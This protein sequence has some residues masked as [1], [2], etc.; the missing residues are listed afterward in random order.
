MKKLI[1]FFTLQIYAYQAFTQVNLFPAYNQTFGTTDIAGTWTDN[2]TFIGWYSNRVTIAHQDVTAAA[3][4]NTGALYSYECSGNNNQKLGSR[5]SG[6]TGTIRYGVRLVNNTAGT[7]HF[8]RITFDAFQFS[9]ADD[10]G[11]QTITCSYLV[12]PTA[13]N[14]NAGGFT[15]I[16]ALNF[17]ALQTNGGACG[18]SQINGFPCTQTANISTCLAVNISSGQE[19]MIKWEDADDSGNDHHMGIDNVNITAYSNSIFDPT[20]SCI[21]PLPVEL[22]YFKLECDNQRINAQ[23]ETSSEINNSHFILQGS[24]DAIQYSDLEIIPGNGNSNVLQNYATSIN[25]IMGYNYFRLVQSDYDGTT[26]YYD[27]KTINCNAHEN[28]FSAYYINDQLYLELP[29]ELGKSS[30][31]VADMTGKTILSKEVDNNTAQLHLNGGI[32]IISLFDQENLKQFVAKVL[33]LR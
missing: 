26:T 27:P 9:L 29:P 13:N 32:Y 30:F 10:C 3:P 12:A 14:I 16:P 1:V 31:T 15:N 24:K 25:N 2:S 19:I 7:I 6:G 5:S 21:S 23:W 22:N 20:N 17:G 18:A 28:T 33:V 11:L 8:L 4:S